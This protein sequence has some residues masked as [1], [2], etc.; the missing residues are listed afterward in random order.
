MTATARRRVHDGAAE[1]EPDR[2]RRDDGQAEERT[3][4]RRRAGARARGHGRRD[5]SR[6]RPRR[7]RGRREPDGGD[8]AEHGVEEPGDRA[9]PGA[10]RA[11]CRPRGA[12]G[13]RSPRAASGAGFVR[14]LA[15]LERGPALVP[16][17]PGSRV[18]GRLRRTCSCSANPAGKTYGSP[19][20]HPRQSSHQ[21]HAPHECVSL[22]QTRS[23]SRGLD[24]G[25]TTSLMVPARRSGAS[26]GV[27]RG[28]SGV[29]VVGRTTTIPSEAK[30]LVKFLK[31]GVCLAL[32]GA[33]L[34]AVP[35]TLAAG[36]GDPGPAASAARPR[37]SQRDAQHRRWHRLGSAPTRPPA[38]SASSAPGRGGDLLPGVA[39]DSKAAAAA[40]ADEYLEHVRRA[41]SAPARA[42]S[43]A[44]RR[45]HDRHGWTASLHPVL[46][47]RPGLRRVAQGPRRQ[48]RRPD[49]GQRLRRPR[50]Q[51]VDAAPR[52]S[53]AEA[54]ARRGR[55]SVAD[56]PP[57]GGQGAKADTSGTR[58]G[59]PH[60]ADVYRTGRSRGARRR[61]VLAYVDRGDQR[62]RTC[63][64]W[65]S[66]TPTPASRSTATR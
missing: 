41:P 16:G 15:S 17:T 21:S 3:G 28:A 40:K 66:S 42:S 1:L 10:D 53:A 34:A 37:W 47:G 24:D 30:H 38:R 55:R 6:G 39:G 60:R 65:S 13:A 64:T 44:V 26:S 11:R 12:V 56:D 59:R 29:P 63:A 23:S 57:P 62:P 51:P 48:R 9:R 2:G 43:S 8:A 31:Q 54:A 27:P 14:F 22:P 50:P 4:R 61:T 52:Q 49:L 20:H 45:R 58:H 19:R 36:G 25:S 33:G 7:C 18:V 35:M 32:L 5:R 46:P